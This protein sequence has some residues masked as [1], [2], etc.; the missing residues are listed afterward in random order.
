MC[1]TGDGA[2]AKVPANKSGHIQCYEDAPLTCSPGAVLVIADE[3]E[4]LL[5]GIDGETTLPKIKL[6]SP[7][8]NIQ[9][10]TGPFPTTCLMAA[11]SPL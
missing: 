4:D 8:I 2:A 6:Q 3:F 7:G 9:I 1:S 10:R 5:D 11:Y